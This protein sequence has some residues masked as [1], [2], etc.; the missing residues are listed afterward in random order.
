MRW[1]INVPDSILFE[2]SMAR[3]IVYLVGNSNNKKLKIVSSTDSISLQDIR[4]FISSRN[5]KITN[6]TRKGL[7]IGESEISSSGHKTMLDATVANLTNNDYKSRGNN[8]G[9]YH[10]RGGYNMISIDGK[11]LTLPTLP[12]PE[13]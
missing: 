10:N 6:N 4:Q 2:K 7:V 5:K 12:F 11:H 13:F 8:D 9:N 3:Y 1:W